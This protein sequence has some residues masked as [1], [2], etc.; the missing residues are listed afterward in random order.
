MAT[1]K[2]D[3]SIVSDRTILAASIRQLD[4]NDLNKQEDSFSYITKVSRQQLLA[5]FVAHDSE[6]LSFMVVK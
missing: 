3:L 6:G 5:G 4:F 2:S 1:Y